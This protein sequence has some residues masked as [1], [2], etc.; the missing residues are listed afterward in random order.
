MLLGRDTGLPQLLTPNLLTEGK[1]VDL[2]IHGNIVLNKVH[3][4]RPPWAWRSKLQSVHEIFSPG[5]TLPQSIN[6]NRAASF[7]RLALSLETKTCCGWEEPWWGE[8]GSRRMICSPASSL[9]VGRADSGSLQNTSDAFVTSSSAI[10]GLGSENCSLEP[11]LR[12]GSTCACSRLC[13]HLHHRY[14]A[15]HSVWVE[16]GAFIFSSCRT[17]LGRDWCSVAWEWLTPAIALPRVSSHRRLVFITGKN[18][19]GS[20][21]DGWTGRI[22]P[23]NTG[24]VHGSTTVDAR[25][26]GW[27]FESGLIEL[28]PRI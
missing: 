7:F 11:F 27:G 15:L 13:R 14:D 18:G 17:G 21:I 6:P 19:W 12:C 10:S 28:G 23:G 8:K 22:K 26:S 16:I 20:W 5:R 4:S 1:G 24:S 9:Q 3:L 25:I 2:V